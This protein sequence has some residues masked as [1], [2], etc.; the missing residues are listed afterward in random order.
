MKNRYLAI[1]LFVVAVVAC[2]R[3]QIHTYRTPRG[4]SLANGASDNSASATHAAPPTSVSD[5]HSDASQ[6][7]KSLVDVAPTH[8]QKMQATGMRALSYQITGDDGKRAM[9]TAS[10]MAWSEASVLNAANLWRE[11]YG[12]A[13]VDSSTVLA[14]PMVKTGV[15]EGTLVDVTSANRKDPP[16]KPERLF[17]VVVRVGETAWYLKLV[18][19]SS[20]VA[21]ESNAYHQWLN[22]LKFDDRKHSNLDASAPLLTNTQP[23]TSPLNGQEL[24]KWS[25]PPTWTIGR[26]NSTRYATMVIHGEDSSTAEVSVSKFP[27]DVGGDLANVNRWRGQLGLPPIAAS[28]LPMLV[29]ILHA[30]DRRLQWVDMTGSNQRC[31]TAWIKHHGET[32]FFKCSGPTPLVTTEKERFIEFVQSIRFTTPDR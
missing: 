21:S 31:L 11:Q 4:A 5:P 3:P 17:G 23:S 24:I 10:H 26:G 22:S 13:G 1:G 19:D 12:Q 30:G 9:V 27:G 25:L 8:W 18:G 7:H 20:L 15:G 14:L 2:K 6:N 29:T 16:A 28:D 32:W